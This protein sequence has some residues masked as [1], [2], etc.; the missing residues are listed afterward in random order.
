MLDFKVGPRGPWGGFKGSTKDTNVI[1]MV[2]FVLSLS[3]LSHIKMIKW[4]KSG[5]FEN[6]RGP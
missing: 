1:G 2:Q 6:C 3:L 4:P 5:S